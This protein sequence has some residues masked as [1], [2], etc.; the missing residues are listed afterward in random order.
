MKKLSI[1]RKNRNEIIIDSKKYLI[2]KKQVKYQLLQDLK[3]FFSKEKSEYRKENNEEITVLVNEKPVDFRRSRFFYVDDQYSIIED[4]K[5][6]SKSLIE[7]YFEIKYSQIDYFETI[8]TLNILLESLEEE[9][10]WEEN[11]K[12]KLNHFSAKQ[13]LK[14]SKPEMI[15][16]FQ[17]DEY[18]LTQEEIILFQ[19]KLIEYIQN[20]NLEFENTIVYVCVSQITNNIFEELDRLQHC[21]V[22]I[23]T[24]FY[25]DKISLD[26]IYL[27]ESQTLDLNNEEMIYYLLSQKLDN[28]YSLDEVKKMLIKY[29]LSAYRC[30][31]NDLLNDIK[32][33]STKN[34]K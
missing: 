23:D 22:L 9:L 10:N 12:I 26:E 15:E 5:M 30:K 19:L 18:D 32:K 33:F 6:S 2:G 13:L 34:L 29:L 28:I 7:K 31:N 17:K 4:C 20:H 14:I 1:I 3:L 24:P 25:D 27:C 21:M 11:L 8:N 16:E